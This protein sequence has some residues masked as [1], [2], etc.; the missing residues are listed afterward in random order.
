MSSVD[1]FEINRACVI[2]TD[3]QIFKAQFLK[4]YKKWV[5]LLSREDALIRKNLSLD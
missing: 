3:T 1:N 4:M 5:I 2:Q